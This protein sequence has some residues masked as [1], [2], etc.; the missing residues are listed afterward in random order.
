M[1]SN[2]RRL[3]VAVLAWPAGVLAAVIL[4]VALPLLGSAG[5]PCVDGPCA[6]QPAPMWENVLLLLAALGPGLVA[7]A[8][9]WSRRGAS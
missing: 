8:V 6:L 4:A 1:S 5:P 2:H 7:T 3:V 9:W